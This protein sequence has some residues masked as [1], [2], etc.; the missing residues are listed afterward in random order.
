[1]ILGLIATLFGCGDGKP[2][3]FSA[4]GYHRGKDKVWY[5]SSTGMGYLVSELK[6][7]DVSTFS[8]RSLK[9]S[10]NG[11]TCDFGVDAT[12]VY[13]GADRIE[14]ADVASFEYVYSGYSRDKNGLFYMSSLLSRDVAHFAVVGDDFVRDAQN[15]YFGS[16][17]FSDDA[18]H[19]AQVGGDGSDFYKDSHR[20]WHF[21]NE[22]QGADPATFRH[23]GAD[24]AADARHLYFHMNPMEGADSRSFQILTEKY[25]KDARR[26][27]LESQP[28]EGADPASFRI[29]DAYHTLDAKRCYYSSQ[30]IPDA[31]PATFQL[32]DSGYA[33][34]AQRVFLLGKVIEGADPG[35]FRVQNNAAGISSDASHYYTM[36]DRKD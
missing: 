19:F 13:Y 20:C 35:T 21:I 6:G 29:L 28:I 7:V 5:K 4:N 2:G 32:V 36:W 22:I 12:Q 9:S 26:V 34:D 8:I 30:V 27:Y 15:V 17:V 31:D 23:L 11:Q 14:G 1:M 33:K 18:A 16:N 10:I 25:S 3:L 24:Y